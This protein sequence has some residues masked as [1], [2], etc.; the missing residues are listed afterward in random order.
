MPRVT[1]QAM[2]THSATDG[3]SLYYELHGES[4]EP[5]LLIMGLGGTLDFWQFQTPVFARTHRVAVY[6][7]RGMGKSDKPKGPYDV[8]TLANDALAILDAAGFD[9]AHVLGM[10]MGGM[11][12]QELALRHPDRIGAL[13]LACTYAKP[14]DDVKVSASGPIDVEAV[15]PK[16]L[17]KFMMSMVLSPEFIA[18]EKQWLRGLR[19]KALETFV[20]E[21]FL[22]QLAATMKH[23]TTAELGN[24]AAPTMIITGTA[25][26]LIPASSSDLLAR[27]I[28]DAKLVKIEGGTH[29][30]N[31]ELPERFNVE[32]LRFLDAHPL[33]ESRF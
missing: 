13:I 17:F 29:G 27:L 10:S 21:G 19:D 31:V 16:D 7:N 6:D 28:P 23:D 4:G 24:I 33:A 8:P 32:V 14:D 11:I 9:R 1:L 20:M 2:P 3:T 25:D 12:A 18:R 5:L 30:F 26:K 22:A 15:A